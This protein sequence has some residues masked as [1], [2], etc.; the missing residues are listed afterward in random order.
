MQK[1]NRTLL[2]PATLIK[3]ENDVKELRKRTF[4][5]CWHVQ[6][7]ESVAMWKIYGGSKNAIVVK[8]TFAKF[9]RVLERIKITEYPHSKIHVN[10]VVYINHHE[11]E[12]YSKA[13]REL[14]RNE[15]LGHEVFFFFLKQEPFQHEKEIRA[16]FQVPSKSK[17]KG[18]YTEEISLPEL[19]DSVVIQPNSPKW[20]KEVVKKA[21]EKFQPTISIDSSQLDIEKYFQ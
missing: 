11:K 12:S 20:F 1:P 2:V 14:T 9:K 13:V 6:A 5:H 16:L 21:L 19:I 18:A 8:S 4:A 3:D 15:Y 7:V 17:K 10:E